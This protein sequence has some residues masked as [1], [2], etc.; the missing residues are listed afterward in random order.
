M[1]QHHGH[2]GG[3][4]RTGPRLS[5]IPYLLTV[6]TSLDVWEQTWNDPSQFPQQHPDSFDLLLEQHP[7]FLRHIDDPAFA[8]LAA[9]WIDSQCAGAEVDMIQP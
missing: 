4:A 3:S 5:E 9:A 2:A 1:L 7:D 8:G 6:E